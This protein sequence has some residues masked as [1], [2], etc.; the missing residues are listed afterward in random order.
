MTTPEQVPQVPQK[1][2]FND[3]ERHKNDSTGINHGLWQDVK[4]NW[5][6]ILAP[7]S[8]LGDPEELDELIHA[9]PSSVEYFLRRFNIK[10]LTYR[11][12]LEQRFV[13]EAVDEILLASN[14]EKVA[15]HDALVAEYNTM[16]GLE[17]RSRQT[18]EKGNRFTPQ[19]ALDIYKR[20]MVL[21]EE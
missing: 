13:S 1:K 19:Q 11:E 5:A 9:V 12:Y 20:A 3:F 8:T 17:Q 16:I 4:S 6:S 7:A 2:S 10:I 14:S 21:F 18:L 15:R